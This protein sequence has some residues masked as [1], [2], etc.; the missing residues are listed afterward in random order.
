MELTPCVLVDIVHMKPQQ[1]NFERETIGTLR[2]SHFRRVLLFLPVIFRGKNEEKT[3]F[4]GSVS[5]AQEAFHSD[6]HCFGSSC[7]SDRLLPMEKEEGGA[8]RYEY[9][10]RSD[11]GGCGPAGSEDLLHGPGARC[12]RGPGHFPGECVRNGI[13]WR[14]CRLRRCLR[15][16]RKY[17]Q[18]F[19]NR[20]FGGCRRDILP[21]GCDGRRVLRQQG[22][23]SLCEDR[24]PGQCRRSP[25]FS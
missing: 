20:F 17:G 13:R 12:L 24:R 21:F 8:G 18:W 9:E 11:A 1:D 5:E 10:Q 14:N 19:R 25:L 23:R 15:Y 16:R 2:T 7:S 3:E 6:Y 4:E 22:K